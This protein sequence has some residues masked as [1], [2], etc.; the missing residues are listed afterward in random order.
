MKL[1]ASFLHKLH[2]LRFSQQKGLHDV[3]QAMFWNS[4]SVCCLPTTNY[5][6]LIWY[7]QSRIIVSKL[8]ITSVDNGELPDLPG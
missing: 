7:K 5:R 6:M 3:A 8:N 2:F 4:S 1:T